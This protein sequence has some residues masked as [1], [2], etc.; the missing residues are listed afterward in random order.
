[1]RKEMEREREP[2]E[3]SERNTERGKEIRETERGVEN[4]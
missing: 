1:M 4:R 3:G 2:I